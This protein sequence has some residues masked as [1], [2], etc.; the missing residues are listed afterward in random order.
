[1]RTFSKD[2][3]EV[4]PQDP[5]KFLNP[6]VFM[7]TVSKELLQWRVSEWKH[8]EESWFWKFAETSG[9]DWDKIKKFKHTSKF[10][11]LH[12]KT[13][14]GNQFCTSSKKAR[15]ETNKQKDL[16]AFCLQ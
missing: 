13:L 15:R 12:L 1:M 5:N 14:V 6:T 9:L 8:H 16:T 11:S 7:G 4:I 3:S 10:S 2:K